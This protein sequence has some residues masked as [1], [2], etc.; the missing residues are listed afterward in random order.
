MTTPGGEV[1][2]SWR[3]SIIELGRQ[4]AAIE[5]A[6]RQFAIALTT[7]GAVSDPDER[8]NTPMYRFLDAESDKI[9]AELL[10]INELSMKEE[11]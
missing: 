11:T 8:F 9:R 5:A 10:R 1:P 7:A 6:R 3:P 2:Q 4:A